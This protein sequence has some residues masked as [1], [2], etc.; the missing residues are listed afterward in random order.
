MPG[1]STNR[2]TSRIAL[3]KAKAQLFKERH[4]KVAMEAQEEYRGRNPPIKVPKQLVR[5]VT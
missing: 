3:A 5:P 2:D 1:K 4:N